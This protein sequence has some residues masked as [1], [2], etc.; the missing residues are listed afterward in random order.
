MTLFTFVPAFVM[1][2][3]CF[4]RIII[5][6]PEFSGK[7]L[8]LQQTPNNQIVLQADRFLYLHHVTGV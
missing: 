5:V 1:M 4:T 6:F 3:T 8:G 2:M 7:A